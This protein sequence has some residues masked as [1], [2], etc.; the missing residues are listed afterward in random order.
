MNRVLAFAAIALAALAAAGC[1]PPTE[2]SEYNNSGLSVA[3]ASNPAV[4]PP[5]WRN[6][7][8]RIDTPPDAMIPGAQTGQA[9]ASGAAPRT[10]G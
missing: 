10:A 4:A 6:P 9:A 5:V 3:V 7:P 1:Q 8:P 2:R